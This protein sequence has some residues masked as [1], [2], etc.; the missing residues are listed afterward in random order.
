MMV[1]RLLS[2]PA[3]LALSLSIMAGQT[4]KKTDVE[5]NSC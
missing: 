5:I 4:A 1:R 2:F 3:V